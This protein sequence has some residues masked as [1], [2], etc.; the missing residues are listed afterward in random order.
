MSDTIKKIN[1]APYIDHTSLKPE[2]NTSDIEK[3]CQEALAWNFKGVC[4]NSRFTSLVSTLLKDSNI[5]PVTV[6][7]FPLGACLTKIKAHEAQLAEADGAKEIDMVIS[8]GGIK[9]QNWDFVESDIKAVCKAVSVPVKVILETCLLSD[10]EIITA[11]KISENAGA[12]Y[13]KT[14]TGFSTGGATLHH[15]AL[16]RKSVSSLMGVKAS[17]GVKSIEQAL[18]FIEAGAT[19]IGTSSGVSLVQG[20]SNNTHK[21]DSS[22]L[23]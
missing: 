21:T 20:T 19:R 16:M 4:V 11:C 22:N 15:V 14:S 6:V 8:V 12:A 7:G 13:V 5:L 3:L 1:L 2:V 17:G 18:Q 9:E 10:E 23:Y